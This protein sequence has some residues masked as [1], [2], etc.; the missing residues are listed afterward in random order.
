MPFDMPRANGE[1]KFIEEMVVDG[2]QAKSVRIGHH[3][4]P[5]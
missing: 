1:V 2:V 5:Q 4:V 3:H